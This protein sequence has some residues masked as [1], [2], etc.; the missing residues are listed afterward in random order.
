VCS[1]CSGDYEDPDM[2]AEA[3][4]PRDFDADLRERVAML[5]GSG[6]PLYELIQ[7]SVARSRLNM[8]ARQL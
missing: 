5:I 2:T 1:A 3:N 7:D 6:D 8:K 4:E